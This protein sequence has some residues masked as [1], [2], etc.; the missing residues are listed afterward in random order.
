MRKLRQWSIGSYIAALEQWI[1]SLKCIGASA[2]EEWSSGASPISTDAVQRRCNA[3]HMQCI[4]V[5]CSTVVLR[6]QCSYMWVSARTLRLLH[7]VLLPSATASRRRC[8]GWRPAGPPQ[9]H[10]RP[11]ELGPALHE[12]SAN[13]APAA[14]L[15]LHW[16]LLARGRHPRPAEAAPRQ[17][18]SRQPSTRGRIF[19]TR[20]PPGVDER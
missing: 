20:S 12:P 13:Q 9:S 7:A 2:V 10:Q 1:S 8:A 6:F 5:Q 19:G 3:A 18:S 16:R 15:Q 4:T 17:L 11:D 14:A